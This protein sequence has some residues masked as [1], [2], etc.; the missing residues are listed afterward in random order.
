MALPTTSGDPTIAPI[1]VERAGN[2]QPSSTFWA[3]TFDRIMNWMAF[4]M[5]SV[6]TLADGASM[7][8]DYSRRTWILPV[9]TAARTVRVQHSTGPTLLG[10]EQIYVKRPGGGAFAYAIKEEGVG[11]GA[12]VTLPASITTGAVLYYDLA[13]T[14]W[15]L[16]IP[17]EG[18]IPG[19]EADS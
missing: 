13:Q 10:G 9:P 3:N 18:A 6:G 14:A 2:D 16:L 5:R 7:T 11:A 15:R 19:V 8:I 4:N 17:G 12:I 1:P